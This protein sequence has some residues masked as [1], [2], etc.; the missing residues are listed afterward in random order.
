[1]SGL[2]ETAETNQQPVNSVTVMADAVFRSRWNAVGG[3][4]FSELGDANQPNILG[5]NT[6]EEPETLGTFWDT[7]AVVV[8]RRGGENKMNLLEVTIHPTCAKVKLHLHLPL[9]DT[10]VHAVILARSGA[11]VQ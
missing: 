11:T 8:G 7:L 6:L 5:V 3:E 9:S 10:D 4:K 1:M 2:D